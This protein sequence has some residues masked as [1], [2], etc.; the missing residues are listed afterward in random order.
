MTDETSGSSA[1]AIPP[2]TT[3]VF[4]PPEPVP[5]GTQWLEKGLPQGD[6][7]KAVQEPKTR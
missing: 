3:E 1:E 2:E 7:E 6:L 4:T 5:G